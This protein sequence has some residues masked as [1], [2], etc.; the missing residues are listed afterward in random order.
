MMANDGEMSETRLDM[1]SERQ[2]AV[3]RECSYTRDQSKRGVYGM[4]LPSRPA[5]IVLMLSES[6]VQ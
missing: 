3:C 2:H 6:R 4:S 1:S 5:L